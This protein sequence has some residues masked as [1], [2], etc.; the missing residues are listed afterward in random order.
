MD[1]KEEQTY[2]RIL[3]LLTFSVIIKWP[4]IWKPLYNSPTQTR[5]Y[6]K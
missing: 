5:G 1:K 6:N 2:R 3:L 4:K